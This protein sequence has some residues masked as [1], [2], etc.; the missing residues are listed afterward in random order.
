M[1]QIKKRG[2][3]GT[4][5]ISIIE[6]IKRNITQKKRMANKPLNDLSIYFIPLKMP[7]TLNFTL[8][9]SI[10]LGINYQESH[11]TKVQSLIEYF[12]SIETFI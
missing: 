4:G 1:Q 12:K 11:S 10:L 8:R 9:T 5:P 6:I 7:S 2:L 3:I